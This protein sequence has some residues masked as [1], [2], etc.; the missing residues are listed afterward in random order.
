MFAKSEKSHDLNK[1]EQRLRVSSP[2]LRDKAIVTLLEVDSCRRWGLQQAWAEA[3]EA[4]PTHAEQ[5][6]DSARVLHTLSAAGD[7]SLW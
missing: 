1:G 2:A 6:S 5:R 3:F 7:P 4:L